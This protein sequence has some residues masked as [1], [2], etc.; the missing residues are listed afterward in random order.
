MNGQT[1]N[2]KAMTQSA[3]AA[4]SLRPGAVRRT[5]SLQSLWSTG[6]E[7]FFPIVGRVRDIKAL[8]DGQFTTLAEDH[9]EARLGFDGY[10]V[11]VTGSR[12][13]QQL[14]GFSSLR[15]GGEMRKAMAAVMPG[16]SRD[17]TRLHRLLDDLAGAA[18]LSFT[19]WLGWEGGARSYSERT[20]MP[21]PAGRDVTDVCISYESGSP[22][23]RADG[24]GREEISRKPE[25]P[26]AVGFTD[27]QAFHALVEYDGPNAW[28]LRRTD[29][30]HEG[31]TLFVDAWL[32]DSC[33][34]FGNPDRRRIFHEYDLSARVDRA[35]L[36]LQS[37]DVT[38]IVLPY[39]TC[40]AAPATAAKMLGHHIAELR[41]LVPAQLRGPAGCTHL[42]DMLRSLIDVE[43]LAAQV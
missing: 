14:S 41:M 24:R 11:S 8:P 12:C 40:E 34:L 7:P 22:S 43:A 5:V 30:W 6:T 21:S 19:A 27:S 20:G 15:P 23:I 10:L 1:S 35:T 28:R 17:A 36:T 33:G 39:L 32:Q 38:P 16:E 25:A 3:T 9:L 18:F 31:D 29:V 13:E 42:N 26:A 4:H 2:M 37:I